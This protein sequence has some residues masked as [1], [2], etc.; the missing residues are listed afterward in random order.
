[1]FFLCHPIILHGIYLLYLLVELIPSDYQKAFLARD[2][3]RRGLVYISTVLH[4]Y[5]RQAASIV[6]DEGIYIASRSKEKNSLRG[7]CF[8]FLERLR[9]WKCMAY[10][11]HNRF[12]W[13]AK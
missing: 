12:L 10:L 1:M 5:F 3:C 4:L 9:D 6:P 8:S 11:S 2:I 13:G 7:K